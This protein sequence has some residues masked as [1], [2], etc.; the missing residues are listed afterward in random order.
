MIEITVMQDANT[1]IK[2]VVEEPE[3]NK[4][5]LHVI[6]KRDC[7][8]CLNSLPATLVCETCK[9]GLIHSHVVHVWGEDGEEVTVYYFKC[10]NCGDI[11]TQE[12]NGK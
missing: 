9:K 11:S 4:E 7:Y 1:L 5:F 8:A 2:F 6:G 10:D 3:R 12:E